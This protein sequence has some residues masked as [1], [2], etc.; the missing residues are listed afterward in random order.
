ML[1]DLSKT[2]PALC[3]G[4]SSS[5]RH[6]PRNRSETRFKRFYFL[7]MKLYSEQIKIAS[8]ASTTPY[9]LFPCWNKGRRLALTRKTTVED[10]QDGALAGFSHPTK[11]PIAVKGSQTRFKRLLGAR[12]V[13]SY[14]SPLKRRHGLLRGLN[15]DS[16]SRL[17]ARNGRR[18]F[19]TVKPIS[20]VSTRQAETKRDEFLL[21]T[22]SLSFRRGRRGFSNS[23]TRRAK[24]NR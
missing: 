19:L 17:K 20:S 7:G 10:F 6:M 11:R 15:G 23:E 18:R 12:Q 9:D 1:V 5:F 4:K 13:I 24:A 8:R 2:I 14:P 21:A 3:R 22:E 16:G